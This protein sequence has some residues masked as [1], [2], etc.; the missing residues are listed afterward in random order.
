MKFKVI[1]ICISF[2]LLSCVSEK[3]SENKPAT[4]QTNSVQTSTTDAGSW[5]LLTEIDKPGFVANSIQ[6]WLKYAIISDSNKDSIYV[7]NTSTEENF[8]SLAPP[9][10]MYLTVASTRLLMPSYENKSVN[11]FRGS[12]I[13]PLECF[14]DLEGP[15][16]VMAYKIDHYMVLDREAAQ[17]VYKRGE[18]ERLIGDGSKGSKLIDPVNF[19]AVDSTQFYIIDNGSKSVKV[20]DDFGEQLLEFGKDQNFQK[21]TGI[22]SDENRIFISDF[23]KGVIYI[24]DYDGNFLGTINQF[25]DNPADLDIKG[26]ILY[27]AN[28][29]GPAIVLLSEIDPN[30]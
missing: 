25:I 26:K 22:T 20:F 28:Q 5:E 24:Y 23:D 7:V 10:P 16:A 1:A 18:I 3:A 15:M 11:V 17:L 29:N 4:I 12:E 9:N 8:D 14:F 21:P 30:D 2:C 13:Y 6:A 27:V 19:E